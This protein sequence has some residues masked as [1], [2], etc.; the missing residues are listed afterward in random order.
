MKTTILTVP[1]K[2][3]GVFAKKKISGHTLIEVCHLLLIKK[4]LVPRELEGYVFECDARHSALALGNGSL[5][6][7]SDFSNARVEM[8]DQTRLL[9][10]YAKRMIKAGEE[11]SIDYGYSKANREK[12]GIV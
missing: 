10:I 2:G 12:F 11:I 5:Y 8:D 7:H 1:L 3:R 9:Y 6:N 4:N